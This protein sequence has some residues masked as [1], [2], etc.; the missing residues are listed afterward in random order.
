VFARRLRNEAE[1]YDVV[2]FVD[3]MAKRHPDTEKWIRIF[4]SITVVFSFFFYVGAQYLGGGKT[5]NTL[6]GIDSKI[7]MS[8][9]ALIILSYTIVRGFRSVAYTDIIQT[10]VMIAIW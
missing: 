6:F 5:L 2:T 9:T 1:K 10:I 4:G 8:I 7:G 3:Y